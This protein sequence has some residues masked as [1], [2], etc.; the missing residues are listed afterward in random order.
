[1]SNI[2]IVVP[3]YNE[4][5]VFQQWLPSLLSVALEVGAGVVVVVDGGEGGEEFGVWS[6]EL[7]VKNGEWAG[8]E[9]MIFL[10][11]LVNC[12]VGAAV[13]TGIEFARRQGAGLV[14]TIDGDGQ[15]DPEDLRTL[16]AELKKGSADIVNGSRFLKHQSIP[17]LRRIYNFLSNVIVF[18]VAGFWLSDS[19]SGMKGFSARAL[20]KLDL[21]SAGYEWCTEVFQEAN[22]YGFSVQ[23]VPIS[24]KY[25]RH[26]L[27]KGQSFAVGVDMIIRL[28][29]RSLLR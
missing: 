17:V 7:G 23:E 8:C 9:R 28:M 29:V 26:S 22:W 11:H 2:C 24:V 27:G 15:H 4:G 19:Q 5:K 12:G 6:G 16:L 3:V 18:L 20:K 1:M 14:L 21:H 25:T 10:R 13:M